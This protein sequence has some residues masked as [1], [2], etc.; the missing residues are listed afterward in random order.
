MGST[1]AFGTAAG[2]SET[3]LR[4]SLGIVFAVLILLWAS[5]HAWKL[6]EGLSEGEAVERFSFR[7]LR[8]LA[9]VILLVAFGYQLNQ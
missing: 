2:L 3:N 9:I 4:G 6:L 5:W 7:F 8:G 1:D